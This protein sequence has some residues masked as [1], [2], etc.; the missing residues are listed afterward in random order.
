MAR[1]VASHAREGRAFARNTPRGDAPR[2]AARSPGLT[3]YDAKS[4]VI[5]T[6]SFRESRPALIQRRKRE[7]TTLFV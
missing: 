3:L 4:N 2:G 1:R 6:G 5:W 7:A